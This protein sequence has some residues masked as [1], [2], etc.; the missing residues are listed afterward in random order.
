MI[1][2]L[3]IVLVAALWIVPGSAGA[4]I[5]FSVTFND[6]NGD[7]T[8][9]ADQIES[10]VIAAGRRWG[11]HL[12]GNAD[13]Q[14]VVRAS[15]AVPYAEGR[16]LTNQFVHTNGAM[17]VFEQGMAAE[18]RTGVDPNGTDP[19]VE[20]EINPGYVTDELWFDPDPSAR[21]A[22][23]DINRTDAMSTFLHEFGH[24]LGYSGWINGTTGTYPGDYQSTYDERINFDGSNF[25]FNGPEAVALHGSPVPLT[26]ANVFHVA[27]FAPLPG[28][29]LL[30][31]LMNGL[32]YYRG[33]RYDVAPL[34]I[35]MLRDAGVPAIYLDGDYD[36]DGSVN[37][38]DYD[39]W[40]GAFGSTTSPFVD[41][42]RDGRVDAADYTVWRNN[43]GANIFSDG[44]GS[45]AVVPE[46]TARLLAFVGMLGWRARSRSN[47]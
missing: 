28:E 1:R 41:G 38:A 30:L 9:A 18:I 7:L 3:S 36:V 16:S 17:N 35:A 19:D 21:T 23:V 4:A 14:V 46:P 25:Y 12:V 29:D 45:L 34:N 24:A 13:I 39:T 27:N 44:G 15:L 2:S 20:I 5:N 26:Y 8:A 40:K 6:P 32:V 42:N 47:G 22:T 37:A 10:H 11:D 33:S 31:D 43:L